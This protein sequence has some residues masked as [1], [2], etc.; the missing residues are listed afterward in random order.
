MFSIIPPISA[1]S[2][3][4]CVLVMQSTHVASLQ[5]LQNISH[6][7]LLWYLHAGRI[8]PSF[9][10][11][12]STTS[13]FFVLSVMWTEMHDEQRSTKQRLQ[14]CSTGFG[15]NW[16]QTTSCPWNVLIVVLC[17]EKLKSVV[18]FWRSK[19]PSNDVLSYAVSWKL[20]LNTDRQ[21]LFLD[22]S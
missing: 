14:W 10:L 22:T 18:W 5:S 21:C 11:I 2:C 3:L 9:L 4:L 6:R 13:C 20:R 17:T 15:H 1:M 12:N 8:G 16:Q 19:F 7:F